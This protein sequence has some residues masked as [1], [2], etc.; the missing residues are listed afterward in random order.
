MHEYGEAWDA[1]FTKAALNLIRN[2]NLKVRSIES[3]LDF[4]ASISPADAAACAQ[5]L[6]DG[7]ANADGAND[8][9]TTAVLTACLATMPAAT[10]KF[11]WPILEACAPL[12]EKV[13]LR[14]AYLSCYDRKSRLPTLSEMQL[15][16][17]YLKIHDLFPP[18]TDTESTDSSV[19]PRQ[20]LSRYRQE[21][22]P[23]LEAKGSEEA[24]IELIRVANALPSEGWLRRCYLNARTIKRRNSWIPPSP[25]AVLT[26]AARAEARFVLDE[27]DL[28][29]VLLESFARFQTQ[30]TQSALPRSEDS[31]HWKG[32]DTRRSDFEPR[33]EAFLC[34][35]VARWLR[36]DLTARGVVIGREVQLRQGQRTDI[37]VSAVAAGRAWRNEENPT[38][39]IE[40]KGCWNRDVRTALAEQ[41]VGQYLRPNGLTHGIYLVGWFV[42]DRWQNPRNRLA[43]RT[44]EYAQ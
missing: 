19:S 21:L 11:A 35:Y 42:C 37:H 15:A 7:S 12:A 36:E 29:E 34:N 38:V 13:L 40:V 17:L 30:L 32:A 25:Q 2:G 44:L 5:E 26:L 27:A 39:V 41:L 14:V 24:C 33:D 8:E 22:I 43:S 6:L 23:I 4:V 18:E 3:I 20:A 1:L 9:L 16:N 31:W 10:W 28:V